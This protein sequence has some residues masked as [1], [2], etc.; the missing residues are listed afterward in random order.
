MSPSNVSG[1]SLIGAMPSPRSTR[2][3]PGIFVAVHAAHPQL[4]VGERGAVDVLV[5]GLRGGMASDGGVRQSTLAGEGR[6]EGASDVGS[7]LGQRRVSRRVVLEPEGSRY[8]RAGSRSAVAPGLL[9]DRRI[10]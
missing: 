10:E 6:G 3:A 7:T 8:N 2:V 9:V 1:F 4:D 5:V